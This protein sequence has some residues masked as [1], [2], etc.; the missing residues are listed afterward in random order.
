MQGAKVQPRSAARR[1]SIV[2]CGMPRWYTGY[3]SSRPTERRSSCT[4]TTGR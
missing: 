4:S 1:C 2:V 3:T